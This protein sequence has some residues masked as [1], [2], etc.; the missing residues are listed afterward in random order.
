MIWYARDSNVTQEHK[1]KGRAKM[2]VKIDYQNGVLKANIA[3]EIDHH[4]AKEVREN[5]D[6]ALYQYKPT[7]LEIDLGEVSFMDSS[8]I[9]LLLGRLNTARELSCEMALVDVPLVVKRMLQMV[10]YERFSGMKI[11]EK[12]S[13]EK[14]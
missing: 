11:K 9:G 6:F 8:G 1:S 3:G 7:H 5:I 14:D 13:K 2:A 10:G 12:E 4:T